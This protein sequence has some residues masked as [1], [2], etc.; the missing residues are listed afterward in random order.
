MVPQMPLLYI[1]IL[2]QTLAAVRKEVV[3]ATMF[4]I[5]SEFCWSICKRQTLT[6]LMSSLISSVQQS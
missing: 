4:G 1:A 6:L 3:A 2:M 5:P